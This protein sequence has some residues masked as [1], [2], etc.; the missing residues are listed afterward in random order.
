MTLD[1]EMKRY[2]QKI[3]E[4]SHYQDPDAKNRISGCPTTDSNKASGV[5]KKISMEQIKPV[6]NLFFQY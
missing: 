4:L 3:L 5:V 6:F 2:F 1:I